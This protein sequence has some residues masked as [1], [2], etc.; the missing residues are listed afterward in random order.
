MRALR[1]T[2]SEP[3]CHA[4]LDM[5]VAAAERAIARKRIKTM[6]R[7]RPKLQCSRLS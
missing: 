4:D 7:V 6:D 2:E 5:A 1:W 3:R